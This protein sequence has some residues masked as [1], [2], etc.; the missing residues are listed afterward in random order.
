[1][2]YLDGIILETDSQRF[3]LTFSSDPVNDSD[4]SMLTKDCHHIVSGFQI[5][6]F[7]LDL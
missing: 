6:I 4:S 3:W 5:S 2:L 7:L 1:S